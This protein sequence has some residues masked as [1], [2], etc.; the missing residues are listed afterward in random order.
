MLANLSG[1]ILPKHFGDALSTDPA[2]EH[3]ID[4]LGSGRDHNDVLSSVG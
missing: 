3:C 2:A 1:P 4:R